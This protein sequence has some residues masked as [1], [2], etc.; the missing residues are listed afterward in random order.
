MVTPIWCLSIGSVVESAVIVIDIISVQ[1][2]V[3]PLCCFVGKDIK[4]KVMAFF[5]AGRS[6]Q[7]ALN[8]S[9]SFIKLKKQI[10]NFNQ[11]AISWSKAGRGNAFFRLC[12]AQCD[13]EIM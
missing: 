6:W 11:T 13:F 1:N 4:Y 8:F 12:K 7:A 5:P 2:L 9:H 10:E 3:A